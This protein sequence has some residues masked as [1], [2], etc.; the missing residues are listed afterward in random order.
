MEGKRCRKE[1][2]DEDSDGGLKKQIDPHKS[3]KN[4]PLTEPVTRKFYS[5]NKPTE[6]SEE[7]G[8]FYL[9]KYFDNKKESF[10]TCGESKITLDAGS[11]GKSGFVLKKFRKYIISGSNT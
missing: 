2:S 1:S 5:S 11:D 7:T 8:L 4:R 3:K 6:E 9:F 10:S